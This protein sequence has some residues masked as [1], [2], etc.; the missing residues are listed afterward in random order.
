MSPELETAY[1]RELFDQYD[2]EKV[3]FCLVLVVSW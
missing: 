1:V 3:A 2:F